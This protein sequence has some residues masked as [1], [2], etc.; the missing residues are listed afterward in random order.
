MALGHAGVV[1]EHVEAAELGFG[2]PDQVGGRI[3]VGDVALQQRVTLARQRRERCAGARRVA[4]VMHADA[5]ALAGAL[6]CG[7][8][9]DAARRAGDQDRSHPDNLRITV[10]AS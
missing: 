9:A 7:R 5:R 8:A 1:D 3:G 10:T 6:D 4:V 2:A